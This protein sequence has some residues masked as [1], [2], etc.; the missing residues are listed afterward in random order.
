MTGP[1]PE[2]I[3]QSA[4]PLSEV[5]W[6]D[7]GATLHA[8]R[9]GGQPFTVTLPSLDAYTRPHPYVGTAIGRVANRIRGGQFEIDGWT[10]QVATNE[11]GNTPHG[12]P[13]GFER[14]DWTLEAHGNSGIEMRHRSPDG[15]QGWPGNL[16]VT[17][18]SEV[19]EGSV[20]I[21]YLATTDAP[22]PVSLTHH[23]YFAL[24]D[25]ERADNHTLRV[26][27]DTY[28]AVG[29]DLLPTEYGVPVAGTE[30]DFR[31]ARQIGDT[32]IDLSFDIPGEGLR[33]QVELSDGTTKLTVLSTLPAVQVYT[34]EALF[35]AGLPARS[36]IAIEP[37]F[38]PDLVNTSRAEEIILR[39]GQTYH[40]VIQYKV[41]HL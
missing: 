25:T 9:L 10:Y 32:S 18:R 8:L 5:S 33:P 29:E 37:Q 26:F 14:Q 11:N 30:Y 17:I 4:G 21:T 24:P 31:D 27:G 20:E 15:H 3:C 1:T 2:I 7:R 28:T 12:G 40:H 41:E 35:E 13:D 23:T 19:S 39:P 6:L 34:G 36:G 16:D 22:T 38:P